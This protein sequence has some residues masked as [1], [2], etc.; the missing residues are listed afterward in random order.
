MLRRKSK[1][2]NSGS[3]PTAPD[4]RTQ[5]HVP[6][7][8]PQDSSPPRTTRLGPGHQLL[9][10]PSTVQRTQ[11][12]D[13]MS[14]VSDL[15]GLSDLNSH[16][17]NNGG[18][19]QPSMSPV[20][21][22]SLLSSQLDPTQVLNALSSFGGLQASTSFDTGFD[23]ALH[24]LPEETPSVL[25]GAAS[26]SSVASGSART[27]FDDMITK[28]PPPS[29]ASSNGAAA[30][31]PSSS[32][33][34]QQDEG[35]EVP[36]WIDFLNDPPSEMTFARRL[37]LWLMRFQWYYKPKVLED[38][39]DRMES[40]AIGASTVFGKAGGPI[41]GGVGQLSFAASEAYPFSHSRRETP[42]LEKAWACTFFMFAIGSWRH[43]RCRCKHAFSSLPLLFVRSRL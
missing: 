39:G 19:N 11:S 14:V 18:G 30:E 34:S 26:S 43:L 9:P 28:D 13:E 36:T 8:P 38:G 40:E 5:L 6:I 31:K 17:N 15:T 16:N 2:S 12:K 10:L 1:R 37:A 20:H 24:V 21:A 41:G 33:S 22:T 7:P 4:S 32:S 23:T 25:R 3:S 42:S 35:E 27:G 29:N